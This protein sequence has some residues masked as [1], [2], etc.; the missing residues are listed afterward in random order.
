MK[1]RITQI[2][3]P[4]SSGLM[5]S[6]ALQFQ[7]DWPG[8]FL[9]GDDAIPLCCSIRSLELRLAGHEDVVVM[10]AIARLK[11]IADII[12]W[13]VIVRDERQGR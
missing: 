9:R 10:S 11:E 8:L 13:D 1:N 5:P 12:E 3:L 7:D 6:G 2:P 4:G